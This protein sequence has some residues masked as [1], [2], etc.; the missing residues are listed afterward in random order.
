MLP[1]KW[2]CFVYA[3]ISNNVLGVVLV[4]CCDLV[5]F[6]VII[7]N[8]LALSFGSCCLQL[9]CMCITKSDVCITSLIGALGNKSTITNRK[10]YINVIITKEKRLSL[11]LILGLPIALLLLQLVSQTSLEEWGLN[12]NWFLSYMI[13][14]FQAQLNQLIQGFIDM[15]GH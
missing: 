3:Y 9:S 4:I 2:L 5:W 11:P 14:A 6:S 7:K 8:L 1:L 15:M 10:R 13:D 12:S